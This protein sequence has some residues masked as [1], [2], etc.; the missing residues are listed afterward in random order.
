[1]PETTGPTTET[2]D[3]LAVT[4]SLDQWD[5]VLWAMTFRPFSERRRP[6]L[7]VATRELLR[8]IARGEALPRDGE[9]VNGG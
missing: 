1:M 3:A 9:G 8:V 6:D 7:D 2:P 4:L 5:V